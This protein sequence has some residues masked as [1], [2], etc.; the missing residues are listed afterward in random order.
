M[1]FSVR[2]C[3]DFRH[4]NETQLANFEVSIIITIR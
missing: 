3:I 4:S 2:I 1:L